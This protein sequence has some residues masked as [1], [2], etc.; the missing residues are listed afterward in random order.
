[1][2]YLPP[3]GL[4]FGRI[5]TAF[6]EGLRALLRILAVHSILITEILIVIVL[7]VLQLSR[8]S[9]HNS[10][11]EVRNSITLWKPKHCGQGC[12]ASAGVR[13]AAGAAGADTFWSEPEPEPSKR[14]LGG[15]GS[16]KGYNCGKKK[17]SSKI[18][19]NSRAKS[20]PKFVINN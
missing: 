11:L 9:Y 2:V 4:Q 16:E 20:L 8:N 18:K 13:A 17:S 19:R 15:S 6:G 10:G 14:K 12:G 1:M 3:N 5:A 7:V